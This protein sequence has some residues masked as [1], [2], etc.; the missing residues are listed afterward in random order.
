MNIGSML[1]SEGCWMQKAPYCMIPS[2]RNVQNRQLH[3]DRKQ[4]GGCEGLGAGEMEMR[5]DR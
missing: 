2:L 1:L 3:R 5:S 4:P